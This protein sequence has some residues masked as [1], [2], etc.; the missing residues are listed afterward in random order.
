MNTKSKLDHANR[1][2]ILNDAFR[3]TFLGGTVCVT[4][5]LQK[6]GPEFVAKALRAVRIDD[7]FAADNDPYGEHDFG[8]VQVCGRKLFWKID[9]FAPDMIHGS[10]DPAN[11]EETRRVLTVMFAEEY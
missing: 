2:A 1:I 5:G 4:A 8:S 10:P 7:N 11:K 3:L 6:M 9:Y